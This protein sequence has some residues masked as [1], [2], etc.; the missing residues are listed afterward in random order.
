ME[1]L[2]KEKKSY[3]KLGFTG[4]ET[5]EI[6]KSLNFLLA[7]YHVFYQKLRNY[8]WNV[9]GGDFF[10]LHDK[11]EEL[12]TEAVTNI[13]EIAERIRVFGMT[14][15]S[16]LR[17]YLENSTI[18]E[19]GT[20]LSDTEMLSEVLKDMET[21]DSFLIEAIDKASEYGDVATMDMLNK[22]AKS[23]EKNHWMLKAFMTR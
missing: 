17:E 7:N 5:Q 18:K 15:M 10:D 8:H 16:T 9:T 14:P 11:F 3:I 23:I 22:M 20:Q 4:E 19:T 12:Y 6:V 2:S 21:M 13:D 1:T